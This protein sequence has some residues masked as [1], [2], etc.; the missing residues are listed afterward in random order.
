VCDGVGIRQVFLNC[1]LNALDAIESK[2]DDFEMQISVTV[3][4]IVKDESSQEHVCIRIK[5]NGKGIEKED[6]D[7]IFDP[8]FTTKAPGKGT[9]LGLFVSHSIVDAH[10]GKT[11]INSTPGKGS[12]VYIQLPCDYSDHY[13][14]V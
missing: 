5:D 2:D 11:W 6:L 9:G 13:N 8:F 14:I 12:T 4:K 10:G 3:E 7:A 1:L